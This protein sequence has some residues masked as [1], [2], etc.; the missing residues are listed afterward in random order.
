MADYK[1]K[2]T[3]A[4]IDK[5]LDSIDNKQDKL[6]GT[7]GQIVMFDSDGNAFAQ[8]M[9]KSDW[10]I[11]DESNPA[12][13]KNRPFYDEGTIEDEIL[14]YETRTAISHNADYTIC[15]YEL[16][17]RFDFK[18]GK[19]YKVTINGKTSEMVLK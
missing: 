1:L 19:K 13:I 18:Y 3:A 17:S 6:T 10:N 2:F 5:K 12:F 11:N 4:E 15:A 9:F 16:E 7:A 8:N 14:P